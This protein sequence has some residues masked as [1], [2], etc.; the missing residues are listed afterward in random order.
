MQE[1]ALSA[2]II[3]YEDMGGSGA[4]IVL[5]H[6]LVM[7]G[8]V[9]RHVVQQ[10]R[11]G[12]RC[13]VPTMPLGS[14]RRPMRPDADL[15]PHGIARLQGELLAALDL[16]DVTL[17]GYDSGLFQI[18]P[19]SYPERIA[20]LAVTRSEAFENFPPGLLGR[21]AD[22]GFKL[23]GGRSSSDSSCAYTPCAAFRSPLDGWRSGRSPPRFSTAGGVQR[24]P[25]GE[26]AAISA[27][28]CAPFRPSC[29]RGLGAG[30]PHYAARA[31][32]AV[33]AVAAART[34]G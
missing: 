28:I 7:G 20:R 31:R 29:A 13:I 5:L 33:N 16:R 34:P 24:R 27:S 1:V 2:G 30:G 3:E 14:H 18:T 10:L 26:S 23:P 22:V 8:S 12:H 21:T 11:N 32:V 19:W 17:V 4:S 6:G 15:S 25:S 9:W